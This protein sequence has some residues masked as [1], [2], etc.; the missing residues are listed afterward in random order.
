MASG[1]GSNPRIQSLVAARRA[2]VGTPE[3]GR[4][5]LHVRGHRRARSGSATDSSIGRTASAHSPDAPDA[6]TDPRR[7]TGP[8]APR[9][10]PGARRS[11]SDP[12]SRPNASPRI[13]SEPRRAPETW[14]KSGCWR[15]TI[16]AGDAQTHA[17]NPWR[18]ADWAPDPHRT[19][20]D[21]PSGIDMQHRDA[22]IRP[23][24]DLYGHHNGRWLAEHEIPADRPSDGAFHALRDA[25]EADV[26]AIIETAAADSAP[27]TL[28]AK[29]GDLYASF[30]DE[31]VGGGPGT[32]AARGGPRRHPCGHGPRGVALGDG[33]AAAAGCGRRVPGAVRQHRR[34][35]LEPLHRVPHAVGTRPARR[36]VLPPG[37]LRE[38]SARPTSPTP[39]GCCCSRD[40]RPTSRTHRRP[41][42]G[43]WRWRPPSPTGTGTTSTPAMP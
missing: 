33:P 5:P 11:R 17:P 27:G 40:G 37:V 12:T 41:P 28:G 18:T 43:S 1:P 23:Q 3:V 25:A 30:M 14:S 9:A 10:R 7:A 29:V 26:R 2:G 19:G 34:P 21:M 42:T 6:A 8:P 31:A 15:A 13:W 38:R 20:A 39:R 22:S 4:D 32:S 35:G 16:V 36:V 24:D